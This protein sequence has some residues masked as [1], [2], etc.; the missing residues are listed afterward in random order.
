MTLPF[1]PFS[2]S[3]IIVGSLK[4]KIFISNDGDMMFVDGALEGTSFANGIS[5]SQLSNIQDAI[6]LDNLVDVSDVEPGKSYIFYRNED[7][8]WK[9]VES[10]HN[11]LV[12]QI[13]LNDW[14]ATTV[15]G[16]EFYYVNIP[17]NFSLDVPV[18]VSVDVW[19]LSN[20]KITMHEIDQGTNIT[21]I[22]SSTKINCY[23][24]I[25]KV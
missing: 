16:L 14:I 21:H 6:S 15:D 24:V 23:V 11:I 13:E 17:H 20:K 1:P 4:N 3:E 10:S 22:K 8:T 7:S 5:L 9:A 18:E 12:V 19:N 2:T 25:K